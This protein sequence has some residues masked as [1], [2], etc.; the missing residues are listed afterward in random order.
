[1]SRLTRM[2]PL[3]GALAAGCGTTSSVPQDMQQPERP[4]AD[5]NQKRAEI[6]TQL[7]GLYYSRGQMSVALDEA[8][9]ALKA[10]PGYGPAYNA[11]GL[12]YM[13]LNED[14]AAAESF[15][16]ALSININDSDAHH[17][18][19]FFLC[20]RGKP[21]EGIRQYLAA[22]R[23][24]LYPTPDNSYAGAAG[25]AREKGDLKLAEDYYQRALKLNPGQPSALLGLAQMR[26]RSGDL[27][28]AGALLARYMQVAQPDPEALW[29]GVRIEHHLGNT[30]SRDSYAV[31]LRNRY[32]GSSQ[33]Q[34]LE[35]GKFE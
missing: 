35:A 32:P 27:R 34:S 24:P 4:K 17:N 30:E 13:Q 31:Q 20:R 15:E 25:C 19:G 16:R 8:R 12:V 14:A 3:L 29:L 28:E 33:A 11:L 9:E 18:Y 1:M 26:Y 21:D 2:L 5:A 23:N 10:D 6:H 7:A 22:V